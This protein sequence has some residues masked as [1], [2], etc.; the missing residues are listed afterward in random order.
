MRKQ[1]RGMMDGIEEPKGFIVRASAAGTQ[2]DM[3]VRES[4]ILKEAWEQM[5]AHFVGDSGQLIMLGPDA[6]QRTLSDHADKRIDVIEVTIMDHLSAAEEW[7]TVYAPDLVTKID[8]IE[9]PDATDDMALFYE[10]DMIGQI[11]SLFDPYVLLPGGG[12]IIVQKTAALTAVDVNKG[13][14]KR[15]NLAVNIEAAQE[16]ARQ[17][18]LRNIGG[19][20]VVDFLG[21]KSKKDEV[22]LSL[23]HI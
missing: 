15:S 18:R 14:D 4:R 2:T 7:C 13:G 17:M 1:I 5:S 19:I 8:A 20:M 21:F 3:L 16:V 6:I 22:A 23:I 11:E 12:S 10:R 9:L